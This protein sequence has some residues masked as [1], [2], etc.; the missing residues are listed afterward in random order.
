MTWFENIPHDTLESNI[1][2]YHCHKNKV[3][4]LYSIPTLPRN[5]LV[6]GRGGASNSEGTCE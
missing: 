4:E 2:Q 5:Y 1:F 6:G 3:S